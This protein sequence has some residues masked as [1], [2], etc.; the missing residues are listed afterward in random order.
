MLKAM[1]FPELEGVGGG[2]TVQVNGLKGL[3]AVT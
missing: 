3:E 2:K 1:S